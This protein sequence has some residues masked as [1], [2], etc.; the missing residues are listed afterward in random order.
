[1]EQKR[2]EG[3]WDCSYCGQK[4]IRARFTE[5]QSCGSPRNISTRFYLPT[6]LQAAALREEEAA[7]TTNEPDWLCSFCETYNRADALVCK[8]CGA[9]KEEAK[10]SYASFHQETGRSFFHNG[11]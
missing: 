7:K 9:A 8:G 4:G 5:C 2:I 1:M 10:G 3:L 6:D 11:N